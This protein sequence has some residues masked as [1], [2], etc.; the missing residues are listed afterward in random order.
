M[1]KSKIR[2]MSILLIII[3]LFTSFASVCLAKSDQEQL[4]ED[5]GQFGS[6]TVFIRDLINSISLIYLT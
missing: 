5:E 1:K 2:I 6:V 4:E 3:M